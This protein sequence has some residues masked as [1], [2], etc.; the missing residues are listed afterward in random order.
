[1]ERLNAVKT[2]ECIHTTVYKEEEK[3]SNFLVYDVPSLFKNLFI[4]AF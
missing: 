2:V 3:G 4:Q 1:M